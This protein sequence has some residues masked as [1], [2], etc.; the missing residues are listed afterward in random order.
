MIDELSTE[1]SAS[2]FGEMD[3]L[4]WAEPLE[5]FEKRMEDQ[6]RSQLK[7]HIR[8]LRLSVYGEA[9]NKTA[10]EHAQWTALAF[11]GISYADIAR[12][13]LANAPHL[14]PESTVRKAVT[15]FAERIS[16]TLLIKRREGM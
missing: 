14:D 15:R 8:M 7:A 3:R 13:D 10:F 12:S 2:F 9:A 5:A 16:L 1:D 6:L 4:G 11:A